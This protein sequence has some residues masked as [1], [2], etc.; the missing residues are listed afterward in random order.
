MVK[1][2][3]KNRKS[4]LQRFWSPSPLS[5]RQWRD[6]ERRFGLR[7]RDLPFREKVEKLRLAFFR[8]GSATV[9]QVRSAAI[10]K[11]L[12]KCHDAIRKLRIELQ[13]KDERQRAVRLFADNAL[14]KVLR[15]ASWGFIN[16]KLFELEQALRNALERVPPDRGGRARKSHQLVR[17]IEGL[18]QLW[19]EGQ[20]AWPL[21]PHWD[22]LFG[23]YRKT[24]FL[25]AV[26]DL[27]DG[28]RSDHGFKR[29]TIVEKVQHVLRNLRS[30]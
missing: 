4:R 6:L 12:S 5:E 1:T 17:V 24:E 18:A 2:A 25:D 10:R 23:D 28:V 26:I 29:R 21:P 20:D 3:A 15:G 8:F 19:R 27:I 22:E 9:P 7:K 14:M 13:P 11:D 16:L 30:A